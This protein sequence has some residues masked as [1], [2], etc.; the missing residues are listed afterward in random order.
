MKE[1]LTEWVRNGGKDRR[2]L[3]MEAMGVEARL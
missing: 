3:C 1:S 2:G